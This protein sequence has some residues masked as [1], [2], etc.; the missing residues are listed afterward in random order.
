[1]LTNVSQTDALREAALFESERQLKLALRAGKMGLWHIDLATSRAIW[2]EQVHRLHGWEPGTFPG[3]WEAF[4]SRI[5][6][7]DLP[8]VREAARTCC[9]KRQNFT[10]QFR[11]VWPDGSLKWIEDH[12]ILDLKA[13][14]EPAGIAGLSLDITA[15]KQTHTQLQTAKE[16]AE[17]ANEVMHGAVERLCEATGTSEVFEALALEAVR[18][19]RADGGAVLQRVGEGMTFEVAALFEEEAKDRGAWA[20]TRAAPY[21]GVGG[22]VSD[23]WFAR[24]AEGRFFAGDPDQASRWS[25]ESAAG[26]RARDYRWFW[27][28]PLRFGSE[29]IGAL[30]LMFSTPRPA[31]PLVVQTLETLAM[32]ASM[33]LRLHHKIDATRET[34][35][36]RERTRSTQARALELEETNALL[37]RSLQQLSSTASPEDL[38]TKLHLEL[39]ALLG[40]ERLSLFELNWRTRRIYGHTVVDSG[41]RVAPG[42]EPFIELDLS[43]DD[44][45]AWKDSLREDRVLR[46]DPQHDA[47]MMSQW[48]VEFMRA[49]GYRWLVNLPLFVQGRPAWVV[50]V[51]GRD[52]A[53][54]TERNLELFRLLARQLTLA[55]KLRQLSD[56]ARQTEAAREREQAARAHADEL[57]RTNEAMRRGSE[58]IAA[59][60]S[61]TAVMGTLLAQATEATGAAGAA[62][63][64]RLAP[65]RA[66]VT[67]VAISQNGRVLEAA[68]LA[69]LPCVAELERVS[70]EDPTGHYAQLFAGNL[71][72][73][74]CDETLAATEPCAA[75]YHHEH[76]H[77][78]VWDYPF[79]EEGEVG[80]WI[81]LAFPEER[82]LDAAALQILSLLSSHVALALKMIRL[83]VFA[84]EAAL[85]EERNRLAGEIHDSLAQSFAGI[86][87]Q[88][89]SA[90]DAALHDE[91]PFALNGL[92]RAREVARFGLAEARRSVLALQPTDALAN[93]LPAALQNLAE[94]SRVDEL[95]ECRLRVVREYE[96][97][98]AEAEMQLFRIAQ[99]AVGNAV[100]HGHPK[101]IVLTLDF[102]EEHVCLEV[103]DDGCGF[104]DPLGTQ[105]ASIGGLRSIHRRLERLG[106]GCEIV[107]LPDQG[108]TL[109]VTIPRRST[110]AT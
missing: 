7:D 92:R 35:V 40:G 45:P 52:E 86:A 31:D 14:G 75:S 98:G 100:R 49:R 46:M 56:A 61:D 85:N 81:S 17:R 15:R 41:R 18:M 80:G 83:S 42:D 64:R 63:K 90:E 27:I 71:R 72:S 10:V 107:S 44:V 21:L 55:L 39:C 38:T 34:A 1:M 50:A 25:A 78:M 30:E 66:Q 108:T 58:A 67:L 91:H 8:Q 57:T 77:F 99:E 53:G 28:V 48:T 102:N 32:Q 84:R 95:L 70:R 88:L 104:A 36:A 62:I 73:R 54:L 9:E 37:S 82:T 23:D 6:P 12:G 60:G 68:D 89:E 29:V 97:F 26:R 59:A 87:M 105:R 106:G 65:G 69:G 2:D 47:M 79:R 101:E 74:R 103:R 43:F 76:G 33:A 110:S 51:M 4:C 16:D 20:A 22:H 96:F 11:V 24:V 5:H 93:G 19:T 3:T 109:R 13:T 94:R